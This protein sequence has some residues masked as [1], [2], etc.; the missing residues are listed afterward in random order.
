[1]F[2][3]LLNT[4]PSSCRVNSRLINYQTVLWDFTQF[5]PLSTNQLLRK[6]TEVKLVTSTPPT[7][8]H[9]AVTFVCAYSQPRS[10]KYIKTAFLLN[11]LIL[12]R[13]VYLPSD[14]TVMLQLG[15]A[16]FSS[17]YKNT[18]GFLS[19]CFHF[20]CKQPWS[21][22]TYLLHTKEAWCQMMSFPQ[23]PHP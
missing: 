1:M 10:C 6:K 4:V 11:G 14:G 21:N 15:S 9:P 5:S 19:T 12:T 2:D 22:S 18:S 16:E 20:P 13:D 23:Q 17:A 3:S 8:I 7:S